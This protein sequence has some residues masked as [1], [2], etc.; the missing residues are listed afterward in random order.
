MH[1]L[2]N[3]YMSLDAESMQQVGTTGLASMVPDPERQTEPTGSARDHPGLLLIHANQ[4]RMRGAGKRKMM[5][6]GQQSDLDT[7]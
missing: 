3:V 1:L 4:E 5:K 6:K 7:A 2:C